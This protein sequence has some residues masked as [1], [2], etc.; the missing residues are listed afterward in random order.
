[1]GIIQLMDISFRVGCRG[2]QDLF[3][4]YAYP[5][6]VYTYIID[7]PP[8]CMYPKGDTVNYRRNAMR[9]LF[10]LSFTKY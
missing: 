9:E 5:K 1:M 8:Y 2:K 4:W 3:Y 10:M 6:L 7:K